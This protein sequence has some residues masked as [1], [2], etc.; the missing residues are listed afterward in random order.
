MSNAKELR[1][2][3]MMKE[4]KGAATYSPEILK[5]AD[6]FAVG[7]KTFLDNARTE[8][9]AVAYVKR[10][11][12]LLQVRQA[13]TFALRARGIGV[14]PR[15]RAPRNVPDIGCDIEVAVFLSRLVSVVAVATVQEEV[16][17]LESENVPH[18]L[19]RSALPAYDAHCEITVVCHY[20]LVF[21]RLPG[22]LR[23]VPKEHF[24]QNH[25]IVPL[26]YRQSLAF[27]S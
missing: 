4:R 8:R 11:A 20:I 21:L 25:S 26:M 17:V 6:D 1:E 9:E 15:I 16:L 13:R 5:E 12:Y 2:K 27:F 7:Y 3:L 23:G 14:K 10:L 22:P 19:H 24:G 18:P